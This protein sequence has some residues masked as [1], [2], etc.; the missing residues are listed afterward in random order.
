MKK[1]EDICRMTQE[2]VKAYMKKYLISK[3]YNVVDEDGFL[4]AKGTN[5]VLLVAHMDTVHTQ[6]CTEII[7]VDGQISSPQGIGGDDRCGIFII[8]NL[9]KEFNCS[10][11][12]CEDE[13]K[14]GQGTNKF[15]KAKYVGIDEQNNPVELKYIDNLDVNYMIEFDR[16]G[17]SD[18]VFYS[19][20]NKDFE[21]F[22]T[23]FTGFKYA[24]G[25]FSDISLLMP[26]AKIA[27]VNLSCGYY[28]PHTTDEY[29]I[30]D[31]MLDTIDAA[32][33]LIK[34]DCKEVFKYVARTYSYASTYDYSTI[35]NRSNTYGHTDRFRTEERKM[36]GTTLFDMV[37]EDDEYVDKRLYKIVKDDNKV[38]MEAIITNEF[39]KEEILYTDGNT[40]AEC[41]RN[42]FI[43]NPNLCF[44]QISDYNWC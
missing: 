44:N 21:E 14:G 40:K 2:E 37:P 9:I 41:W 13:E 1:F 6:Q 42:L 19:C 4:Y 20:A 31:E 7:N 15:I 18:A 23:D 27:A 22:V 10:V 38:E 8:M 34:A 11:L 12:L 32:R 43:E 5:P 17:N 16:K 25:S 39:G 33:L 3:K 28:K 26:A 24:Y 36:Y 35:Y 30:Y 29:V